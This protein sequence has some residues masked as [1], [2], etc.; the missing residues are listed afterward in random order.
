VSVKTLLANIAADYQKSTPGSRQTFD[1]ARKVLPGGVSGNLRYFAPYPLYM[2]GGSGARTFDVD[3]RS[4]IDC[5]LCNGPLLLGHRNPSVVEA[6]ARAADYGPLVLNPDIL[7]QCAEELCDL[8]P[9]AEQVRFLNSGTEAL[10]SAVRYARGYTGRSKILKFFG[11]YHGQ[12]D[13]FLIGA[14]PRREPFSKG[15]AAS[16]YAETLTIPINDTQALCQAIAENKGAIAAAVLDPAMHAG[17]LWGVDRSFLDALRRITRDEGIVLILDEVITGFRLAPG[18][19]QEVYGITPD[20]ATYAKA[21][22]AGERL[23]AVAGS[24]EIMQVVDPVAGDPSRR[25]FQSGTGNDSTAGLLAATAAM[26]AYRR[27][28]SDGEYDRLGRVAENL[29]GGLIEVFAEF[30][31]PL[32]VNQ[33]GSMLQLFLTE[34]D[35]DFSTFYDL[36]QTLID[37]FYLAMMTEGVVLSLPTS[38]HIYLSFEHGD[39]EVAAILEAARAVLGRYAFSNAFKDNG[40]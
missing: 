39:A 7:A 1:R 22:G 29:A 25:V 8:I 28:G 31:L 35:P 16:A 2:K 4:Y 19:A 27:L 3:G 10:M 38:N 34:Q 11:H 30:D 24:A 13:Q 23:A 15:I 14:S 6:I 17:G 5:F 32:R 18:G 36:D 21:L 9:C 40:D 37:A 26:Q 20:L 12:D 33:R